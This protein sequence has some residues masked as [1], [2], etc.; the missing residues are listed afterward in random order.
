MAS[1]G[2]GTGIVALN[3]AEDRL[4]VNMSFS[5]LTTPAN[6]AHIH[7]PGAAGMNAP[8]LFD[9]A[10]VVPN[11][12]AGSI[13]QQIFAITPA[14]VAELKAGLYYFNIHTA[15]F[16]NGE[17]RGQITFP[18][19]SVDHTALRF[20]AVSTGAR[21]T[22]QT[23]AQ[24]VRLLQSGAGTVTWTAQSNQPWL[25]VTPAAGSGSATLTIGVQFAN[26]VPI[27]GEVSGMITLVFTGGGTIP[28]PIDVTLTL[29]P[30]GTTG[31]P[32]GIVD[33]P[34]ENANDVTGAVPFHGLG[35][36]DIEVSTV[37]I[38]RA[39]VTGEPVPFDTRCGSTAKIFVGNA[40]FIDG[41]RPDVQGAFPSFPRS[42]RAGWGF[43]VL[44][45]MLPAQ[46][47]GTTRS[48]CTSPTVMNTRFS[49]APG[50]SPAATRPRSSRSAPS[51]RP[52]R[53]RRFRGRPYVNFGWALTPQVKTIPVE[54]ST[55]TVRNRR[56]AGRQRELRPL[57]GRHRQPV[58][59]VEQHRRRGRVP[60]DRHHDARQRPAHD[61]V[62]RER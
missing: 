53:V 51:T 61:C 18:N 19:M 50:R 44:T 6:M 28:A 34:L 21:F 17:I 4:I 29:L 9:F 14:Q 32:F 2:T 39:G 3:A 33:T 55:L 30:Q 12:T 16:P 54:G 57:P 7:G 31:A 52:A 59:R 35:L 5:G 27:N 24:A 56:P 41:A 11:A 26:G 45:N 20:G 60:D 1:A 42:T 25:T 49:S 13:P 43:M 46:G 62:E 48:S 22:S 47:N 58:P 15:N 40:V 10:A 36:D 38:C 8:V 37:A 23:S